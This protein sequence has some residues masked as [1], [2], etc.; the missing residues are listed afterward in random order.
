MQVLTSVNRWEKGQRG[1]I[2]ESTGG[3]GSKYAPV[4]MGLVYNHN[5]KKRR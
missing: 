4:M 3:Q 1:G 2:N 5:I